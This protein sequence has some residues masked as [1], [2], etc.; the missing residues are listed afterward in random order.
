MYKNLTKPIK[1]Q[2]QCN[3]SKFCTQTCNINNS[4]CFNDQISNFLRVPCAFKIILFCQVG[5]KTNVIS[6]S[7]CCLW[8]AWERIVCRFPLNGL[9]RKSLV[10]D[11][12]KFL[13][14]TTGTYTTILIT[15]MLLFL[16]Y[17]KAPIRQTR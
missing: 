2:I 4:N 15:K 16:F 12:P 6:S 7:A 8:E 13:S 9:Y 5:G 14:W 10:L 11:S 3:I 1:I 17:R